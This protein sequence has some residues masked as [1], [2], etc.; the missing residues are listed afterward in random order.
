MLCELPAVEQSSSEGGLT[1]RQ[2]VKASACLLQIAELLRHDSLREEGTH[3][4]CH[5]APDASVTQ[6]GPPE[7]EAP[8]RTELGAEKLEAGVESGRTAAAEKRAPLPKEPGAL[9]DE[10]LLEADEPAGSQQIPP[11]ALSADDHLAAAEVAMM[12]MTKLLREALTTSPR[13]RRELA[14]S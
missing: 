5:Q 2:L 11:F 4:A 13:G 8:L 10:A 3:D 6:E 14:T 7:V 12:Q 1:E 9:A